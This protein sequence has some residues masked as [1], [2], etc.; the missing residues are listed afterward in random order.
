RCTRAFAWLLL[1]VLILPLA[2]RTVVIVAGSRIVLAAAEPIEKATRLRPGPLPVGLVLLVP[3]P[4]RLGLHGHA[5][6]L[7]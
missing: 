2:R 3:V 7:G 5:G 1:R 6:R 4:E